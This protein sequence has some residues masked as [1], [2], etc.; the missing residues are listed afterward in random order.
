MQ[1]AYKLHGVHRHYDWGGTQYIPQLMQ[2]KN[3]QNKPFA[4]YWMGAHASAPAIIDTDQFGSIALDQLL[5]KDKSLGN[6]PY[7]YK[8]LDVASMLS[9]Q[10]HPNKSDAAI[11]FEKEEKAGISL[12]A[13]NRNYKDKNHKPEVMVALSDFWLLHGFLAPALMQK[14]LNEFQPFKGLVN[15]FAN[16]DYK[17][18]YQHFMQLETADSDAIL[19]PLLE[20]AVASVKNGSVD[21]MHPHWW[22][23]KYYQGVVP[24]AHVDKGIFSIYILNI[25]YIPKNHGIFQGAGLLHAYLEGQNIELMANSD[26]VLRGGL[27]PKHVDM[28]ELMQHVLF[29]PTYPAVMEGTPINPT[30]VN[31]PC[32]VS[33]FGLSKLAIKAGESYTIHTQSIEM[34]LVMEGQMELQGQI[35]QAGEVALIK[36]EQAI[37]LGSSK[38]VLIFRSFAP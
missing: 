4:E 33:D 30:E 35:Y 31:Y 26:N 28:N 38:G 23:N 25:V 34:L 22:A 14:R 7:L 15:A 1:T 18:L 24:S 12:T 5:Q 32:P 6:L 19:I 16:D 29:K 17:N 20:E 21:K 36:P 9:I 10:V 3:D 13:S 2:L 8:I 11:G 37:S 27:T